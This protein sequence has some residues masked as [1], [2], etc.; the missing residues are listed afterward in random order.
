[1]NKKVVVTGGTGFIGRHA[2]EALT[3][4]HFPIMIIDN[5][6]NCQSQSKD[7]DI[8]ISPSRRSG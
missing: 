1:M 5:F 7:L 8:S 4:Q 2:L 6:S 3:Q